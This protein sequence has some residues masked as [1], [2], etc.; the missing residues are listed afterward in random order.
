MLASGGG[1]GP[2]GAEHGDGSIVQGNHGG[3]DGDHRHSLTR[4]PLRRQ[5][6]AW[7][8]KAGLPIADTLE[9]AL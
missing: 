8:S 2:G 4:M 1:Q 5:S 7:V 3:G 6:A 9:A